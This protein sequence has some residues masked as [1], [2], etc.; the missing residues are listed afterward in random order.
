MPDTT[1]RAAM[2]RPC[3]SVS[4]AGRRQHILDAASI[5]AGAVGYDGMTMREVA[6]EAGM[7]TATIYRYFTSKAHVLVA[8]WGEWLEDFDRDLHNAEGTPTGIRL[9]HM[10]V[11]MFDA[12]RRCPGFADAVIRAYAF[13][14]ADAATEVESVRFHLSEIFAETIG[15]GSLT[16]Y[17]LAIGGLM[18]DVWAA[19]AIAVSQGRVTPDE[20]RH[21]LGTTAHL[22][23]NS[24]PLVRSETGFASRLDM[25]PGTTVFAAPSG[26]RRAATLR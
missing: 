26:A 2:P 21:R 4:R 20:F 25:P 23:V 22:I 10:A 24:P 19:N 7:S 1:V 13:A 18:S 8:A 15:G 12:L 17:H 5:V 3:A 11:T 9:H 14:D 6:E 16:D